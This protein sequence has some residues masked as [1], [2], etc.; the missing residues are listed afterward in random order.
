MS[1]SEKLISGILWGIAILLVI[2]QLIGCTPMPGGK[3]FPGLTHATQLQD[4]P[5]L[6]VHKLSLPVSAAICQWVMFKERPIFSL[7]FL[8][9]IWACADVRPDGKGGV[10]SCEVWAPSFLMKHELEHCKG[11]ADKWY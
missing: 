1:K 11:W 10:Q 8:G 3:L 2:S 9:G 4:I 6:K 7:I 5:D